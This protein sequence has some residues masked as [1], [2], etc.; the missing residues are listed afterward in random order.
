MDWLEAHNPHIDWITKSLQ[1]ETPEGQVCLQGHRHNQLQCSTISA[2]ELSIVCRQGSVAHLVHVYALGD[3]VH[4]TEVTPDEV[5]GLLSQFSDVF[6]EPKTLPPRRNCDHTIPLIQGAQ[7]VNIRAYRHKP[8]LKNEIVRQV[9]EL[10]ASGIIQ[11][12][13]SQFSSPAILV[14]KKD[15]T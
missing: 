4:T 15:G 7:P 14:K 6:S 1:I 2:F 13:T 12:S 8:E 10:L 11:R 5:H 3:V 9:A